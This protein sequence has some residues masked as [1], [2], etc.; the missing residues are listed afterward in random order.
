MFGLGI[1]ELLIIFI[2]ALLIFGPKKLPDLG[3]ALGRGIA[4]F[5]KASDEIRDGIVSQIRLDEQ[6]VSQHPAAQAQ[7]QAE[8]ASSPPSPEVQADLQGPS[9]PF[10]EVKADQPSEGSDVPQAEATPSQTKEPPHA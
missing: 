8:Q 2:I 4:E 1:Q 6:E 5:R 10:D 7:P 9:T 3:K